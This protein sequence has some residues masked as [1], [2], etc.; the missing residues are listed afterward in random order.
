MAISLFCWPRGTISAGDDDDDD[1]VW[2]LLRLDA[3]EADGSS[4]VDVGSSGVDAV[5]TMRLPLPLPSLSAPPPPP[6]L[7][8]KRL[9]VAALGAGRACFHISSRPPV[10]MP[11]LTFSRMRFT[12]SVDMPAIE[13][14]SRI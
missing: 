9:P 7:F 12:N 14:S 6:L 2:L 10:G 8:V 13:S 4:S 5:A 3:I 11:A 1:D